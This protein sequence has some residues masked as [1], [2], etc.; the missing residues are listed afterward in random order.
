MST[1]LLRADAG[2]QIGMGHVMRCLAL[3]E[4]WLQAGS[5][6]T[7]LTAPRAGGLQPPSAGSDNPTERRLQTAG[8]DALRARAE[9]LSV[10]LRELSAPPGSPADAAET[11]AL[12][13]SLR[14]TWLVLDGYHFDAAFQRAV[15]A[16]RIR[17]LVFDDTAQAARYSADFI[18]NQNLGAT[19]ALYPHRD[20]TTHLLLGPRFV[21]LR[22][23]FTRG[24]AQTSTARLPS[25]APTGGE[26]RG[27][28]ASPTPHLLVTL[29]GSD[30]DNVTAQVLSILQTIPNLT[31]DIILGP[32]NPHA[33]SLQSAIG[34]RPSAITLHQNPPDLPQLMSRAD[35]AIC[36]G[37]TTAWEL[38]FLGVPMLVLVLA[39][40]QRPNAERLAQ[41]GA[42][43][44]TTIASLSADLRS[45]L[46]D[47]PRRAEM[48][49]RARALV[50]GLGTFRV[51][52]RM[53]EDSLHLRPATTD[54]CRRVWQWANDPAVRA[55][56]FTSDPILWEQHTAWFTRK[57]A[58][59]N[60]RLWIAEQAGAP[61]SEPALGSGEWLR[62][63]LETGAPPLGQ[64]R[65]DLEG[66]IA[67]I[68]VSLDA[69]RRGKNLGALLI[70]TAC[71]K[72]FRESAVEAIHAF[73]KPDNAASIRAFEKAGFEPA[74]QTEVKGCAALR[75]ELKRS[76][77]EP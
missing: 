39:E 23:E 46:A 11:I 10:S 64:V 34:N 63:G 60:T 44:H 28:G 49:R 37:G 30:P 15:K 52:L 29:G 73:I 8:T 26:G 17:L 72:L 25:L 56:S 45:L 36:A 14:A 3:A 42:A 69:S 57:L 77:A 19:A 62:A 22:G 7:L 55:V 66:C 35:L 20:P 27:E 75:F 5:T 48:S 18:L 41:T 33:A 53:N 59:A 67:T 47:A 6:V 21:Q 2:P 4:P 31:A 65:F 40:N 13:Q 24:A 71:Q 76:A 9:S 51:W 12:A 32:A 1:L 43:I 68:S 58:D 50:D 70:W 16:A 54:D 61:V 74:G 38:S